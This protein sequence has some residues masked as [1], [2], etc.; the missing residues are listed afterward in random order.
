MCEDCNRHK[1]HHN[2]LVKYFDLCMREDCNECLAGC[3]VSAAILIHA[4]ARIATLDVS[5]T[6]WRRYY[7]ESC[8][9]EDCNRFGS[10]WSALLKSFRFMHARGL[11]PTGL[12]DPPYLY[13][14]LIH[15]CVRIAMVLQLYALCSR[16]ILIHS[17]A[18]I[19]VSC[20]RQRWKDMGILIHVCAR[21]ATGTVPA[22]GHLRGIL[23]HTCAKIAT[24]YAA[25]RPSF[26]VSYFNSCM[27]EDCSI[28]CA[29]VPTSLKDFDSCMCEDCNT[30]VF[31]VMMTTRGFQFMYAQG[32]QSDI[33]HI[34]DWA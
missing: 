17:C 16:M 33:G 8:M 4:C 22:P 23:I 6:G 10:M 30:T 21:I 26:A 34:W 11:Q 25:P 31:P 29:A 1:A 3:T 24:A 12:G 19:A 20:I 7:F 13:P 9:R 5:M 28:I 27:R 14:I 2:H 15:A 32:L 18:R